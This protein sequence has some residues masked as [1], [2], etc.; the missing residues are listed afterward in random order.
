M[1]IKTNY[2][3]VPCWKEVNVKSH[4]P[5]SLKML[6]EMARNIW[7]AWSDEATEMFSSL[8]PELW[9]VVGQNPVALLERISYENWKICLLTKLF[10]PRLTRYI[11]NSKNI[12]M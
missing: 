9:S 1:K 4:I 7:W 12:L 6:E 5:E 8:D 2:A 10:L 11:R 3:N